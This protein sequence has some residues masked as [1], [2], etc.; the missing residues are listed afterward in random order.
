MQTNFFLKNCCAGDNIYQNPVK[1]TI[2]KSSV[3]LTLL[4]IIL[5]STN[6]QTF[7]HPGGLHTLSDLDRMKAK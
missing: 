4:L 5:H 3:I 7:V 1:K 2:F 6:A